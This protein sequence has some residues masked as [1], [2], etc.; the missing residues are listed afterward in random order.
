MLLQDQA[1]SMG[2]TGRQRGLRAEPHHDPIFMHMRLRSSFW[3]REQKAA[4]V[5]STH[6]Y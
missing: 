1:E 6:V 2:V 5:L 3:G 4:R